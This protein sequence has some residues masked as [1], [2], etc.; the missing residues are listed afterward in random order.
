[1]TPA[2]YV[3][4]IIKDHCEGQGF[5]VTVNHMPDQKD[6]MVTIYDERGA[7]M[8]D[9]RFRTGE[10]DEHPMVDI[11]VRGAANTGNAASL[12][13]KSLWDDIF[14]DLYARTLEDGKILRCITKNNT[15]VSLGQEPQKRRWLFSQQFRMTLE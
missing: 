12:L 13:L 15:I 6:N 8:E 10:V 3:Y 5:Q 11:M 9:R 7:R 14:V 2:E 1:M 4:E